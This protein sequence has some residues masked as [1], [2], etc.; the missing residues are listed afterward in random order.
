MW[1]RLIRPLRYLLKAFRDNDSPSQLALGV[2][3]G[4]MV[5]LLPKDNLL[6]VGVGMILLASR[7]N[8]ASASL[9]ALAFSWLAA[10][11]DPLAHRI[12]FWLLSLEPLN[13]IYVGLF[14]LPLVAWTKLNNTV[15][16]G[17][18]VLGLVLAY[19]VYRISRR[20]IESHGPRLADRL[21]QAKLHEFV[22]GQWTSPSGE[23]K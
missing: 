10:W 18:L 7:A 13:G 17:N 14:S 9:S 4:M 16:M 3:L 21:R 15:V 2:A 23:I 20:L 6:A 19:P 11:A 12:G 1:L 8:L 22:F 5:G